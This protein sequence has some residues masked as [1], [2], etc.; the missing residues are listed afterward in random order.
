MTAFEDLRRRN[1]IVEHTLQSGGTTEDCAIALAAH[2]ER[3]VQRLMTLEGIAPRRIRVPGGRVMIW[4]CP[5]DLIPET[6]MSGMTETT[7]EEA[8]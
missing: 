4:R 3:L 5:D 8:K 2:I 7:N 6:D 1:P